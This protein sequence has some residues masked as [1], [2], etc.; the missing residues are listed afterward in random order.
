MAKVKSASSFSKFLM[1]SGNK[2]KSHKKPHTK[3]HTKTHTKSHTKTHTKQHTK[4]H[5]KSHTKSH[6]KLHIKSKTNKSFGI[7]IKNTNKIYNIITS[8][9]TL[10]API[11]S[12]IIKYNDNNSKSLIRNGLQ[13]IDYSSNDLNYSK[14]DAIFQRIDIVYKVQQN[15]LEK[16]NISKLPKKVQYALE[17]MT[18]GL[19]KFISTRYQST[20]PHI[21]ISNAFIKMWEILST[22]DLIHTSNYNNNHNN[23]NNKL[24]RVFHI[25]EA[26]G[27]MILATRYYAESKNSYGKL[28]NLEYEWRANSLN[29]FNSIVKN[30]FG[31]VFGDEYG[32]MK[33]NPQKWIWGADNTGDITQTENIKWY[34]KYMFNNNGK[35]HS[36]DIIIGDGGLGSGNDAIILQRLDLAQ[37]IMVIAC[38]SKGGSCVIK[39]FTPYMVNHPDTIKATG[40]FI[41]FMYLYY[42]VFDDIALFKPY[43]SDMTSGEF[44][45]I[46]KEFRGNDVINE[47]ILN[48]LYKILENFKVNMTFFKKKDIPETFIMQINGFI[49]KM[50]DYNIQGYEKSNLLLTC[51]SESDKD[52]KIKKDNISKKLNTLLYCNDFLDE[53]KIEKILVPRYYQWIKKYK[54]V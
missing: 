11:T 13:N 18:R 52:Y 32:L 2:T 4:Q 36:P 40:F 23:N 25:C 39:H 5:T 28:N 43:S 54:F 16:L 17:D 29:P 44:Y 20:L 53:D 33:E 48:K 8:F 12:Y 46:G 15:I 24:F 19:S 1:V 42:L 47:S 51:M 7:N 49:E 38:S 10:H 30:K 45:V 31:R 50:A 34:R 27:Q 37:V 35:F 41:N 26:P 14:T 3:S 9:Y 21:T 22:F 6:T